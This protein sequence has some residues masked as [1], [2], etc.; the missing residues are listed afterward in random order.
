MPGQLPEFDLKKNVEKVKQGF[1]ILVIGAILVRTIPFLFQMFNLRGYFIYSMA[2]VVGVVVL[3]LGILILLIAFYENIMYNKDLH[4]HVRIGMF[5]IIF[6]LL[7]G[8]L[9][10]GL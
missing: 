6:I 8:A 2:S 3:F 1:I 9:V 5:I 10:A 4:N 7:Y